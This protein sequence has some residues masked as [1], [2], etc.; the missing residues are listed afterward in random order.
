[1]IQI[2]R[3]AT[4]FVL[5]VGFGLIFLQHFEVMDVYIPPLHMA[6]YFLAITIPLVILHPVLLYMH[7]KNEFKNVYPK[8]QVFV[9]LAMML[10]FALYYLN[11]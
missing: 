8:Q 6:A 2:V 10:L 7:N 9:A 5:F 3:Y 4:I 11:F 1:M